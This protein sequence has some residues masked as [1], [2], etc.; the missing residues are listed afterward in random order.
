MKK[1]IVRGSVKVYD[2]NYKME[3]ERILPLIKVKANSLEEALDRGESILHEGDKIKK[4]SEE[5]TKE[6]F[7]LCAAI[8]DGCSIDE[9]GICTCGV[10]V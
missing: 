9:S 1:Y 6:R 4:Q 5:K 8:R 10:G 7:D 3:E 2:L